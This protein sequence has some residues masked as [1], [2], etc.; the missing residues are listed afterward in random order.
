MPEFPAQTTLQRWLKGGTLE[1]F[2]AEKEHLTY[3]A[4]PL[5]Y[6]IF[7]MFLARFHGIVEL[8]VKVT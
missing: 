8:Q 1:C 5:P 4:L 7:V 3:F 2:K 6:F